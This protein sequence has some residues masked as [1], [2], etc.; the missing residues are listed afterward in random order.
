M[1]TRTILTAA[2]GGVL[3]LA[4]ITGTVGGFATGRATAP[5]PD[6]CI[7]AL[8]EGERVLG[9]SADA[10]E[11]SADAVVAAASWDTAALERIALDVEGITADMGDGVGY[12]TAA[13]ECRDDAR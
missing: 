6:A 4:G 5:T 10:L 11:L 12:R 3:A 2:A 9:L 8:E 1:N 13:A 7:I